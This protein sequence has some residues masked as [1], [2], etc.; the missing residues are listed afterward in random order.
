MFRKLLLATA[1]AAGPAGVLATPAP[2]R[3]TP[4][5][6]A[7]VVVTVRGPRG[8]WEQTFRDANQAA[9][10]AAQYRSLGYAVAVRYKGPG[11]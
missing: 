3:A 10:F 9:R 8:A 11:G 1:L 7:V 2:A 5:R 6:G 4:P